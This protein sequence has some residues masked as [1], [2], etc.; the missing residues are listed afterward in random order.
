MLRKWLIYEAGQRRRAAAQQQV[1][2]Q[3]GIA[4]EQ[5]VVMLLMLIAWQSRVKAAGRLA[6]T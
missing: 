6:S 1:Q 5:H 3:I 4:L 2:Q